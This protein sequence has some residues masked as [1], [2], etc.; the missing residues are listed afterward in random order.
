M[1]KIYSYIL[2]FDDGA[3]PNPFWGICTLAI[4]KPVIRR[5]AEIGQWVIGT[6]SVNG[7]SNGKRENL[8]DRLVY[9]MKITDKMSLAEYNE[10]CLKDLKHKI[11]FPDTQDWRMQ[12]GDC[13]YFDAGNEKLDL[14]PDSIHKIEHRE[15]DLRGKNVLLSTDFYYFGAN[16]IFIPSHL[17][18]LIKKN[19]GHLKIEDPELLR[20]F[21]KW[22]RSFV[23]NELFGAPQLMHEFDKQN[24]KVSN[25]CS[26]DYI[27]EDENEEEEIISKC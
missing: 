18:R 1:S 27:A 8:S 9:A 24:F 7:Y 22:I 26:A 5:K 13:I 21:E 10:Y 16:A 14:R 25:H 20:Q 19:Q 15:R 23:Q 6:G 12:M 11:P 17:Q 4:C 2:R 3:A